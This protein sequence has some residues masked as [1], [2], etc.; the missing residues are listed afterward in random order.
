M[1][2]SIV[3]LPYGDKRRFCQIFI[4]FC[5]FFQRFIIIYIQGFETGDVVTVA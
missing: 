3:I 5:G 2:I 4:K 1:C